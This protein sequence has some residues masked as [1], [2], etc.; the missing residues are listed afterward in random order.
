MR[1][2]LESRFEVVHHVKPSAS[3]EES[4]EVYLLAMKYL[5]KETKEKNLSEFEKML[6]EARRV[7]TKPK[8]IK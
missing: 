6:E 2:Y 7:R 3:R 1:S 8:K 5:P 4:P